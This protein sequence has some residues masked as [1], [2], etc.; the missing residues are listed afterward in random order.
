[1]AARGLA[2]NL[3]EPQNRAVRGGVALERYRVDDY[4]LFAPVR[5]GPIVA[6]AQVDTGAKRS[7]VRRSFATEFP[8]VGR[9]HMR[10]ALHQTEVEQCRAAGVS[11][12]GRDFAALVLSVQP[13]ELCGYATLPFPVAMTAGIDMLYGAPLFLNFT[14]REIGFVEP[15][16]SPGADSAP[17]AALELVRGFALFDLTLGGQRLRALFDTGAGYSV[18]NARHL[19]GLLGELREAAAENVTDPAGGDAV[20]PV[21]A[22]DS[23]SISGHSLGPGRFLVMDLTSVEQAM[24]ATVD[25]VFGFD[26]MVNHAWVVDVPGG[27]LV[28]TGGPAPSQTGRGQRGR[29]R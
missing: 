9:G 26:T 16:W 28:R 27:R 12:L 14:A 13:D 19:E 29:G 11:L 2:G 5:L 8:R 23:L 21:Y 25:F 4:R 24:S 17:V 22:H 3:P 7:F 6:Y 18:L 20:V 10:G 15:S 1:M